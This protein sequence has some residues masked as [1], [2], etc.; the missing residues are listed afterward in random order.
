MVRWN[1]NDICKDHGRL[2]NEHCDMG[3]KII[4]F[5]DLLT[6]FWM[7]CFLTKEAEINFD[8]LKMFTACL[9]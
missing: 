1:K 9:E 2:L 8:Y 7:V 5:Q 6:V 3:K 4:L